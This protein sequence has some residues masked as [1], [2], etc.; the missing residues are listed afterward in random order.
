MTCYTWPTT[1]DTWWG[2]NILSKFQIFTKSES[3]TQL[4]NLKDVCRTAPATPGLLNI[5]SVALLTWS[6]FTRATSSL[7]MDVIH[8]CC[9]KSHA[10]CFPIVQ[11][12]HFQPLGCWSGCKPFVCEPHL[13]FRLQQIKEGLRMPDN[14]DNPCV[15][16]ALRSKMIQ[17]SLVKVNICF[18]N[19]LLLWRGSRNIMQEKEGKNKTQWHHMWWETVSGKLNE[20]YRVWLVYGKILT[21]IFLHKSQDM[22]V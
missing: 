11:L 16:I 9:K 14:I 3:L 20:R 1:S 4:I 17:N 15:H 6:I 13:D 7:S 12:F 5:P 22:S 2:V 10:F 19:D 21:F 8:G 18:V